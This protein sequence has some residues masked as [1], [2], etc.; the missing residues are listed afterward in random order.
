MAIF[1][2]HMVR[3]IL[4][5]VGIVLTDFKGINFKKFD[6]LYAEVN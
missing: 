3:I 5:T 6:G 1:E 2:D 4:Y